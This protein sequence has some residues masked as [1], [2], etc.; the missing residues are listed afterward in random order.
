[1][2]C[3]RHAHFHMETFL[4]RTNQNEMNK[5][6]PK[7]L[8]FNMKHV[9]C[10]VDHTLMK[11]FR[12]RNLSEFSFVSKIMLFPFNQRDVKQVELCKLSLETFSLHTTQRWITTTADFNSC[13]NWFARL[14]LELQ[15]VCFFPLVVWRITEQNIS[16]LHFLC[17]PPC[18]FWIKTSLPK[19]AAHFTAVADVLKQSVS[20]NL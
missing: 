4:R 17:P 18:F 2:F 8:L 13:K 15:G 7:Q 16:L 5:P 3:W 14:E 19:I 6:L 1:M 20:K 9:L 11:T 12:L 10:R